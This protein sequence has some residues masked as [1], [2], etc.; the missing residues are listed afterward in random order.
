MLPRQQTLQQRL[1]AMRISADLAQWIQTLRTIPHLPPETLDMTSGVLL[2]AEDLARAGGYDVVT[3]AHLQ[4]AFRQL[5][6]LTARRK[7]KKPR[8]RRQKRR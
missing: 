7:G 5:E 1:N 2:Y 6:A 8:R 3:L 4:E